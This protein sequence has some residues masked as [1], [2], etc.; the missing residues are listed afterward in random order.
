MTKK[1]YNIYI[2]QKFD[3]LTIVS[4][5]DKKNNGKLAKCQCDCGNFHNRNLIS[6]LRTQNSLLRI[7]HCGCLRGAEGYR[8]GKIPNDAICGWR[9]GAKSRDIK[10]DIDLNH[11][12]DL[13]NKQKE[14]CAIT[15]MDITF[16]SVFH[17]IER[18]ASL[19]RIDSNKHYY[20][21][22]VQFV[23]KDINKIKW[24]SDLDS[25][26]QWCKIIAEFNKGKE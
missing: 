26:I 24:D 5:S 3:H 23:H 11:L 22:N 15:G 2:G 12:A 7:N 19:D 6:L 13:F 10:W 16:G 17:K 14:K 4:L 25:F 9:N 1:N 20:I 18:T 8:F 21:E